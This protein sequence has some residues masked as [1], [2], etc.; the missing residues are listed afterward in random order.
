MAEWL[1]VTWAAVGQQDTYFVYLYLHSLRWAFFVP[2]DVL[3]QLLKS[4]TAISHKIT[5]ATAWPI[6][7]YLESLMIRKHVYIVVINTSHAVGFALLRYSGDD[8]VRATYITSA[9]GLIDC[10]S[11]STSLHKL[12]WLSTYRSYLMH[13]SW[14]EAHIL[15]SQKIR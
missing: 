10:E 14:H 15:L 8:I 12:V 1:L 3:Y 13:R 5:S 7:C 11:Y 9:N 4:S 6:K 2:R